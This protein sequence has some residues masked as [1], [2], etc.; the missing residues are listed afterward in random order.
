[1]L[2]CGVTSLIYAGNTTN[3]VNKKK[4]F[5]NKSAPWCWPPILL[6]LIHEIPEHGID[7]DQRRQFT[8]YYHVTT[9]HVDV[10]CSMLS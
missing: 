10:L 1:M 5:G 2:R 8:Y 7:S 4:L 9:Y 3:G 6:V